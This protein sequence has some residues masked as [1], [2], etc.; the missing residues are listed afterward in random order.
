[1]TKKYEITD[2]IHPTK[3]HLRRI[4][5]LRDIPVIGVKAGDFGGWI[6]H[7]YNLD[8]TGPA[9]VRDEAQVYGMAQV[10]DSAQVYGS[11]RVSGMARVADSAHV[12]GMAR[13]FGSAR[14]DGSAWVLGMARVYGMARVSGSA[15]VD[16]MARV[17]G[18]AQVYGSALVA[19]SAIVQSS[20]DIMHSM[21][22]ASDEYGATLH[23]TTDGHLLTV[24]CWRGTVPEFRSMIESD[25]WVEATPDQIKLRRPELLAFAS[26]CE[27]RIATWE[28]P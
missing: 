6:E 14:V 19:D 3:P 8:H 9:W 20:E 12:Y 4:R 1:M 13:V 16:G 7:E 21:V 28:Q 11:A 18:M 2:M 24:G 22:L 26:M 25:T 15:R 17:F 5:A 27:A 10:T 23:R